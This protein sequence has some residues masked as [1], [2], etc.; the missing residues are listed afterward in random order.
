MD[1]DY[2]IK[3]IIANLSANKLAVINDSIIVQV[4]KLSSRAFKAIEKHTKGNFTIK[5]LE[6]IITNPDYDFSKIRNIGNKTEEELIAFFKL[7][8]RQIVS[9][10]T[11]SNIGSNIIQ[12]D[13]FNHFLK[14]KFYFK[15]KQIHSLWDNYSHIEG[16][17]IFKAIDMLLKDDVGFKKKDRTFIRKILYLEESVPYTMKDLAKESGLTKER[18]R[19][20]RESLLLKIS[21]YIL[22]FKELNTNLFVVYKVDLKKDLFII[23]DDLT[24]IIRKTENVKFN[25]YFI[26]LIIG[27]I[28][29]RT[30]S[31]LGRITK[32]LYYKRP[33]TFT[34]IPEWKSVYI[35]KKELNEKVDI[36]AIITDLYSKQIQTI[37]ETYHVQTN[38]FINRFANEQ[39]ETKEFKRIERIVKLMANRELDIKITD[40]VTIKRTKLKPMYEYATEALK[41]IGEPTHYEEIHKR[42]LEMYPDFDKTEE[43]VRYSM[44]T[45]HYFR[46]LG[47]QNIWWFKDESTDYKEG[48]TQDLVIEYLQQYDEPKHIDEIFNY[49]KELRDGITVRN[50]LANLKSVENKKFIFFYRYVGLVDNNYS[51]ECMARMNSMAKD[52]WSMNLRA[53]GAFIEE[54]NR[55]PSHNNSKEEKKLYNFYAMQRYYLRNNKLSEERKKEFN[56]LIKKY[57]ITIKFL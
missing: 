9:I 44:A 18:I 31:I 14:D 24:E 51:D 17:P 32:S 50:L 47:R 19:Q 38:D 35:A 13:A 25:K 37:S 21:Q 26:G 7:L 8:R 54:H 16:V 12:A 36:N 56:E 22:L 4:K 45:S 28:N 53:L 20:I 43:Q 27:L 46:T 39:L 11:Y 2:K 41:D 5:K 55:L 42:I 10:S 30:H 6:E 23:D 40:K 29:N 57:N 1:K 3:E 52:K 15:D 34:Y 33:A 48:T 49:M